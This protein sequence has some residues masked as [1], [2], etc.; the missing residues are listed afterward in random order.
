MCQESSTLSAGPMELLAKH[1]FGSG[2]RL[3]ESPIWKGD[4]TLWWVDAKQGRVH[5]L[6]WEAGLHRV[7][8]LGIF[9]TAIAL[10]R[11]AG[12]FAGFITASTT[13]LYIWDERFDHKQFLV[14]PCAHLPG[15]RLNDCVAD[16]FGRLWTGSL[17]QER[18]DS[19]EGALYRVDPDGGVHEMDTGFS[20]A[21]GIA[22]SPSGDRLYVSN[23]FQYQIFVY[24]HDPKTGSLK[25][26]RV[27]V[28][29][30]PED[31]KPDG[32]CVDAE[33]YV[34]VG[35]WLGGQVTRRHP[36][37][38]ACERSVK[39]P[40]SH[41]TRATFGGRDFRRLIVTTAWHGVE[42]DLPNQPLAGDVFFADVGCAGMP[43]GAFGA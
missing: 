24:D 22:L 30:S 34:W 17:N 38:G 27:L 8:E 7:F 16:R 42:A 28:E 10:R 41:A 26:K 13:G 21:N 15:I 6:D 32:L 43:E 12:K 37:S 31:G 40:V 19:P 29:L 23:M 5:S 3:G 33:G 39:L 11:V 18:L 4:G 25:N 36:E 1:R 2:C 9:V 20:V 14:D 35:H